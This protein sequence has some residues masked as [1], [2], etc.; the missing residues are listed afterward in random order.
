[1]LLIRISSIM[2]VSAGQG[3]RGLGCVNPQPLLRRSSEE[4][5]GRINDWDVLKA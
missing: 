1:M 5:A 4:I 3:E 2:V